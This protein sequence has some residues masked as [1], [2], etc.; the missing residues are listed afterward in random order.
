MIS[1]QTNRV[2]DT[3]TASFS[4]NLSGETDAQTPLPDRDAFD[5]SFKV[6]VLLF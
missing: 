6:E 5:K 1:H 3:H 4:T 2:G